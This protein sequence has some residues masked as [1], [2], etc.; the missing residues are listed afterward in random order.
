M[1]HYMAVLVP[2]PEGSWHVHFPDF[3]GCRA[4]GAHLQQAIGAARQAA[5]QR[6]D[7]AAAN[8]AVPIPR[9]LGAIIADSDWTR[10]RGVDWRRAVISLI[11]FAGGTSDIV[12]QK[13]SS[14]LP[15]RAAE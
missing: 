8:G 7:T 15:S 4:E 5:F 6:L 14:G 13:H 2:Q 11:P 3:P 10:T 9:A 1:L 12:S